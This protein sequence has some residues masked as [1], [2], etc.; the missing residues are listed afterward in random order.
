MFCFIVGSAISGSFTTFDG[1][2]HIFYDATN[3]FGVLDTSGAPTYQLN[4]NTPP[5]PV[6]GNIITLYRTS[7]INSLIGI[8]SSNKQTA[9]LYLVYKDTSLH[10]DAVSDF[11]GS[12]GTAFMD[13]YDESNNVMLVSDTQ[14]VWFNF[15]LDGAI[16]KIV[17]PIASMPISNLQS[18]T[19]SGDLAMF[20]HSDKIVYYQITAN[21][22]VTKV[23]QHIHKGPITLPTGDYSKKYWFTC[24]CQLI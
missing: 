12:S 6:A 13:F 22:A 4:T 10:I 23:F 2:E 21:D 15:G 18:V 8:Y 1:V 14:V 11:T 5:N 7:T 20:T 3:G 16:K 17:S 9:N 24:F 19:F